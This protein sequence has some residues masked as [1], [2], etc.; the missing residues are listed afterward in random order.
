MG[1][2]RWGALAIGVMAG[3]GVTA[4]AALALFALGLRPTS[5]ESGIPFIFVQFTGQLAAGYV[6]GRFG[7]PEVFHGS[8]AALALFLVTTMLTLATGGEPSVYTLFFSG[9]IALVVGAAGGV[10]A[11]ATRDPEGSG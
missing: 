3:L 8:Q 9:F 11:A 7:T 2:L 5:E 4:L 10:L 1:H 6:A